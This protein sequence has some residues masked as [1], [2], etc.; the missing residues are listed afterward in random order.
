[1]AV[2][3]IFDG[4]DGASD[5][6]AVQ[7]SIGHGD[8]SAGM[9]YA[10]DLIHDL[11]FAVKDLLSVIADQKTFMAVQLQR[12]GNLAGI[13]IVSSGADRNTQPFFIHC[14]QKD[15]PVSFTDLFFLI[16]QRSVQIQY[17]QFYFTHI[18]I[19]LSG[20]FYYISLMPH[21]VSCIYQNV[22]GS[23][24]KPDICE[25]QISGISCSMII[26]LSV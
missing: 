12:F 19:S 3:E 7:F 18:K 20:V 24:E 26:Q 21:I 13:V 14:L 9:G 15:F 10:A 23:R 16:Q 11:C 17:Q 1:M 25:S 4:S 2:M 8:P 22:W 5:L 6:Q